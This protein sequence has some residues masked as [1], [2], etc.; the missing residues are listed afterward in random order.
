MFLLLLMRDY[1]GIKL[2]VTACCLGF[3]YSAFSFHRVECCIIPD[4]YGL[5]ALSKLICTWMQGN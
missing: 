3:F 1:E 4:E 2:L 5:C